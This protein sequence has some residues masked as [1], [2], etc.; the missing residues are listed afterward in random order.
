MTF[1]IFGIVFFVTA[2]LSEIVEGLLKLHDKKYQK[3]NGKKNY[4]C[5]YPLQKNPFVYF[6]ILQRRLLK[7]T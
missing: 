3:K 7:R 4:L 1:R 2:I 6:Q 5:Y